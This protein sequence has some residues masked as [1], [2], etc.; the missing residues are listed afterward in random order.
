MPSLATRTRSQCLRFHSRGSLSRASELNAGGILG[1]GRYGVQ[2]LISS[3]STHLPEI[4][5]DI[6]LITEATTRGLSENLDRDAKKVQ[7]RRQM[8]QD[9][10]AR[11]KKKINEES[12][13]MSSPWI[14]SLGCNKFVS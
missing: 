10:E 11:V 6:R 9:Q 13:H 7:K 3:D 4:R 8:L 12:E 14:D 1:G 2:D 5:H